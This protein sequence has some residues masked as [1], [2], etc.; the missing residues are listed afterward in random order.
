MINRGYILHSSR[1]LPHC[2]FCGIAFKRT[3]QPFSVG[4]IYSPVN[5]TSSRHHPV[6]TGDWTAT[7]LS[8]PSSPTTP[9]NNYYWV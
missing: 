8:T 9:E 7:C 2:V 5:T 3:I 4:T 6:R 1:V